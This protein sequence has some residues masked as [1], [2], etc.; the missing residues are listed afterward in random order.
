MVGFEP[1]T[2]AGS[3]RG[4]GIAHKINTPTQYAGHNIEFPQIMY[5]SL[6]TLINALRRIVETALTGTETTNVISKAMK[7]MEVTG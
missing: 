3:G 2:E 5:E 4:A 6:L 7:A 1:G